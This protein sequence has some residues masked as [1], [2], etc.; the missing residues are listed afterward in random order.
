MRNPVLLAI[1]L[2]PSLAFA[3]GGRRFTIEDVVRI[4]IAENPRMT[5][6]RARAE[7]AHDM[8]KSSGGRLLPAIAMRDEYKH[9]DSA[10]YPA[11][12]LPGAPA[13]KAR[14]QDTNTFV[15]AASQPL[16]GLL[17]RAEDYKAQAS[18]AHAADAGVAVAEAATREALELEYLRM[19][20]AHVMEAI[21]KAS[22]NELTEQVAVTAARVKAGTLTDADLLRV[23][24]AQAN[25]RQQGISAR[26]RA[27]VSRANLLSAIGLPPADVGIEFVEPTALLE[28]ATAAA[29]TRSPQVLD[30]KPE[31]ARAKLA[32]DAAVHQEHAR[33]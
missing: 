28:G 27:T 11:F 15:A 1:V 10:F 5:A 29:N 2:L 22:E 33:G 23:R 25:A 24:V 8:E 21:A 16:V 17:R 19:F 26:T 14:D 9:Y 13:I 3:E 30:R 7:S 32:A 4:A 20:Q 18:S 6:A 12:P 31:I